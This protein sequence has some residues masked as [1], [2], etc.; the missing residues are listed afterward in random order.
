[1]CGFYFLGFMDLF[2]ITKIKKILDF[3]S[4]YKKDR[5]EY[6]QTLHESLQLN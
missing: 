2:L 3:I 4:Y 5:K 1:M 6:L